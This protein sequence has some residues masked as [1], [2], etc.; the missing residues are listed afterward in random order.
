[1][2]LCVELCADDD[3]ETADIEPQQRQDDGAKRSVRFLVVSEI[4]YVV[5]EGERREEPHSTAP[6]KARC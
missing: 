2:D 3:R 5:T 1:M 6:S 4:D